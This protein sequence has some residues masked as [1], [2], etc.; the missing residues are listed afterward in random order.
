MTEH[1][2]AVFAKRIHKNIL[3]AGVRCGRKVPRKSGEQ[4]HNQTET[5]RQPTGPEHGTDNL[6]VIVIFL[7]NLVKRK[8]SKQRHRHLKHS[9]RH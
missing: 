3:H 9:Q 8:E 6:F 5:A 1:R 2:P 7:Y 4:G